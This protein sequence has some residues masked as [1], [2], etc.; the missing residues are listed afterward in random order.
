MEGTAEEENADVSRK[1]GWKVREREKAHHAPHYRLRSVV[2]ATP[3]SLRYHH[4]RHVPHTHDFVMSRKSLPALPDL[5][6]LALVCAVRPADKQEKQDVRT[7]HA[8]TWHVVRDAHH[9][10]EAQAVR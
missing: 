3:P 1:W 4:P 2:Q 7:R 8:H 9:A 6:H 10:R 5:L